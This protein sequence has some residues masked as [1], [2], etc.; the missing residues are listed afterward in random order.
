[1]AQELGADDVRVHALVNVA[2]VHL[3]AD[4]DAEAPMW[5]AVAEG[6]ATGQHH[7][8]TRGMGNLAYSLMTGDRPAR[9][10]EIIEQAITYAQQHEVETLRQYLL[11]MQGHVALLEGRWDEAAAILSGTVD[12]G[13]SVPHLLA[14]TSLALLQVRRGDDGA[15]ATLDQAWPLAEAAG[16]PQRVV[17]LAEVEAERAWLEGRL[18]LSTRRLRDAFAMSRSAVGAH[19]RLAV[20]LQEAGGLDGVPADLAEPYR[21]ELEGRWT[22]AA[23]VWRERGM[24]YEEAM[25]LARGGPAERRRALQIAEDLGAVPLVRRLRVQDVGR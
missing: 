11:A 17:P 22:D 6:E 16:E 3:R 9:S 7:E 1:L 13:S 20:W 18:D 8:V 23:S 10:A 12:A 24:P 25:A 21:S 5:A 2:T 4:L 14:L 19:G 15:E